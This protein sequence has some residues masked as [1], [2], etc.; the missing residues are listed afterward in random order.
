MKWFHVFRGHFGNITLAKYLMKWRCVFCQNWLHI[1]MIS[2]YNQTNLISETVGLVGKTFRDPVRAFRPI[3][4]D[5]IQLVIQFLY[6]S[7]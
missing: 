4:T 6:N 3:Q 5:Q 7:I 2:K 1:L